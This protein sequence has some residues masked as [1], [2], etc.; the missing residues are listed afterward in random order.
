MI[1]RT[2]AIAGGGGKTELKVV[3]GTASI[4]IG[5]ASVRNLYI[6][7][8]D[9]EPLVMVAYAK[10]Y[11][12]ASNGTTKATTGIAPQYRVDVD[13]ALSTFTMGSGSYIVG[14]NYTEATGVV[15]A[16]LTNATTDSY[17]GSSV[18]IYYLFMGV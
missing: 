1:G 11:S 8:L 17:L 4:K 18:T 5:S 9:F 10:E 6:T 16:S 15:E 7:T 12:S 13:S 3:V 2:N 14:T